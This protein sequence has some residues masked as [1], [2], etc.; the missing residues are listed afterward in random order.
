ML[1]LSRVFGCV[2]LSSLSVYA[3]GDDGKKATPGAGGEHASAG[4]PS[5]AAGSDTGGSDTGGSENAGGSGATLGGTGNAGEPTQPPAAGAGGDAPSGEGGSGGASEP[6]VGGAGG[7]S[8]CELGEAASAATNQALDLFGTVVYFDDG[9]QLP[10]GRYRVTYLDGCMKYAST[11]D[12]TIHAYANGENAAWWLVGASTGDRVVVPPGTSGYAT[13]NGAY[14]T[15]EECVAANAALAPIEFDFAGGK[16]GVWVLDSNYG[17][18]VAGTDGR[19][20]KWKLTLLG[21]C[22]E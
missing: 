16:L 10:A 17:D 3:C 19:N 1:K 20:P 12:W 5:T 7:A 2:L 8:T 21:D 11:Q 6:E 15:F 22:I 13:S 4:E 14:A 9:A 18:N